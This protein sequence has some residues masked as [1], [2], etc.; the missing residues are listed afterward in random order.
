MSALKRVLLERDDQAVKQ[1]I[2][3]TASFTSSSHHISRSSS[4]QLERSS[5]YQLHF[6]NEDDLDDILPDDDFLCDWD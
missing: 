6:G 3:K 2:P 1:D 5:S 4:Y